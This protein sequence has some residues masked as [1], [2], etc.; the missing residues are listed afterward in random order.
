MGS[1]FGMEGKWGR[2]NKPPGTIKTSK[3]PGAVSK[4]CVGTMLSA[5]RGLACSVPSLGDD[6]VDTGSRVAA[7][8]ERVIVFSRERELRMS[9]GPNTSVGSWI[10]EMRW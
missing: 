9:R 5:N 7:M 3:S 6:L 10:S 4:V 2:V 8:I 1:G